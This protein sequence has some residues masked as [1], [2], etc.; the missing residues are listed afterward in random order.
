MY[1]GVNIYQNEQDPNALKEAFGSRNY[2]DNSTTRYIYNRQ[3][4]YTG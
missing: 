1:G 2:Y 3:N 4:E